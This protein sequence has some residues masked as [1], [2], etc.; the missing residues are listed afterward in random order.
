MP[1]Q[2]KAC[3]ER[4]V[5]KCQERHMQKLRDMKSSIDNKEPRMASHLKTKAKKNALVEERLK[6]IETENR[7]LLEKMS[8]IMRCKGSID[9]KNSSSQ[10]GRS[11]NKDQRKREL[12]RITKQNKQILRRLSE[13]RPTY[14]HLKWKQEAKTNDNILSNICEFKKPL[15]RGSTLR[16]GQR[17]IT[18]AT[19]SY[20]EHQHGYQDEYDNSEGGYYYDGKQDEDEYDDE[21]FE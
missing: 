18:T 6:Q 15:K 5:K 3:N 16:P 19:S 4:H 20:E 12:T 11:L 2:N 1:V 8:H 13:S 17:R 7:L 9:N 10:Y 21:S 14:N